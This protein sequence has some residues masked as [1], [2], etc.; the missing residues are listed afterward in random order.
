MRTRSVRSRCCVLIRTLEADHDPIPRVSSRTMC[1]AIWALYAIYRFA[2]SQGMIGDI[3]YRL[4]EFVTAA[5]SGGL[6][7][8]MVKW[9]G[10]KRTLYI[11][12]FFGA[13]GMIDRRAGQNRR[14]VTRFDPDHFTLE[15]FHASRAE[16]DDSSRQRAR[17]RRTTRRDPEHA[18]DHV[19]YWP[20]VY[21]LR[22]FGWFIDPKHHDPPSRRPVLSGSRFSFHCDANVDTQSSKHRSN[23]K[24]PCRRAC[25]WCHQRSPRLALRRLPKRKKIFE[26][27]GRVSD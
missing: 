4:S 5:I 2:W 8:R 23:H 25:R 1:L 18:F 10:E 15:H 9:F 16:H 11:G 17:T 26:H 3:A 20:M 21:S 19:H 27:S 12:Q 13:I 22:I 7:G 14:V 6:T 24:R